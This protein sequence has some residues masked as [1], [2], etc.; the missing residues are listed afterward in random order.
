MALKSERA[1]GVASMDQSKIIVFP[2]SVIYYDYRKKQVNRDS[3]PISLRQP[4]R[5]LQKAI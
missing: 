4:K 5:L 2:I 3:Q 1:L